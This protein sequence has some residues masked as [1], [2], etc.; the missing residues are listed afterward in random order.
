MFIL[1]YE[2]GLA[3]E[4]IMFSISRVTVSTVISGNKAR[5]HHDII[6]EAWCPNE[7]PNSHKANN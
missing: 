6:G 2:P 4:R 7:L 3:I 5:K 1:R